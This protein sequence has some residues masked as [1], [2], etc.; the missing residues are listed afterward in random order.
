VIGLY[1][2]FEFRVNKKLPMI[3]SR[4]ASHLFLLHPTQL[5]SVF[6]ERIKTM[7]SCAAS[8]KVVG[9]ARLIL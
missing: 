7:R 2:C 1:D 6:V 8:A 5:E 9:K 4:A 3:A